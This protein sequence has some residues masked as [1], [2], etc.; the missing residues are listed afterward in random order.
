MIS[1]IYLFINNCVDS[2]LLRYIL[3]MGVDKLLLKS[4]LINVNNL[5]NNNSLQLVSRSELLP[6][7]IIII[8]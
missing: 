3:F 8:Y 7:G 2:L 1:I 4:K 6:G 5:L